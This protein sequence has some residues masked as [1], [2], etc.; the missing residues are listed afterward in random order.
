MS[1]K[2]LD[3]KNLAETP[4]LVPTNKPSTK[5]KDCLADVIGNAFK[6]I[7]GAIGEII[8]D[9]T[10]IFK[11]AIN[12]IKQF[13]EGLK[14]IVSCIDLEFK[15]EKISIKGIL[16]DIKNAVK[17]G[18]QDAINFG[19]GILDAAKEARAFLTCQKGTAYARDA[20]VIDTQLSR[21]ND[22]TEASGEAMTRAQFTSPTT[23][24][25]KAMSPKMRRDISNGAPAGNKYITT[26]INNS[27]TNTLIGVK[28][29]ARKECGNNNSTTNLTGIADSLNVSNY[30]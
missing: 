21:A 1:Y 9:V 5:K 29:N 30:G 23:G 28:T 3:P 8:D 12:D 11:G 26:E 2:D 19:K 27:A 25:K 20:A 16:D 18:I 24:T 6:Q 15:L 10:G 4:K 14:G 7:K 17:G 22:E 13:G